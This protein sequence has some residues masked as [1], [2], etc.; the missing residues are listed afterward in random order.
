MVGIELPGL[1]IF[2]FYHLAELGCWNWNL[3]LPSPSPNLMLFSALIK[4]ALGF[5]KITF[6][7]FRGKTFNK[8]WKALL[9]VFLASLFHCKHSLAPHFSLKGSY[10]RQVAGAR[11]AHPGGRGN[12]TFF[13]LTS[14]IYDLTDG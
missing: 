2:L 13:F 9:M 12:L 7:P 4:N 10:L 1:V 3:A 8:W 14:K 5:R 6:H 11:P